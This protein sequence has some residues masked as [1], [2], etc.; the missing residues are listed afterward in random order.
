MH[1]FFLQEELEPVFMGIFTLEAIIKLIALKCAYF[2]D[3]W[4]C[5]DFV[6][7]IG[8][9]LALVV[10]FMTPDSNL[11]MQATMVR[12]LRVLRVLRIIKRA[13]KL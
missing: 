13:Q 10:S 9:L 12:I 7:V 2:R 5:F 11:S 4:N 8:S 6:V 1:F 3:A